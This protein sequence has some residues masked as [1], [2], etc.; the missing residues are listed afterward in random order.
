[1]VLHVDSDAAYLVLPNAKSRIARHYY[2]STNPPSPP[3]PPQPAR[4]GPILTECKTLK[5][6]VAS[7]AEAETG[8][9]FYNGQTIIPIRQALEAL[10]HK[11]PTTPLKTDNSTA[12]VFVHRSLRQKRSKS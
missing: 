2:L 12:R 11:Q 8:G 4:N 9:L 3:A 5:H 6:V 10:G 7:A 1:M